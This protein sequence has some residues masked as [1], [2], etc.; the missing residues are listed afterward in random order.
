[1]MPRMG[2]KKPHLTGEDVLFL[3]VRR[4]YTV[5]YRLIGEDIVIVRVLD[6]EAEV[7]SLSG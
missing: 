2:V 3:A 7:S 4:K 6:I 5:V 1:M